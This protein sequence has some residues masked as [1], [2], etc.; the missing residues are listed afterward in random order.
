[1]TSDKL[2]Y[3]ASRRRF[4]RDSTLASIGL[5]AA[6]CA[7]GSTGTTTGG[8]TG[9]AAVGKGGEFHGAW[10]YVLPPAGHWN[11]YAPNGILTTGIYRHL[12]L[13]TLGMY[14][15]NDKKF[16]Y[17][18]AESS[19]PKAGDN[20]ELKLRSGIKWSDGAAFT[21]K[22]VYTTFN[23]GRLENFTLWQYV[24]K[25][26][27]V[28]DQTI[29]FHFSRPSGLAER[30]LL[31]EPIRPDSLFGTYSKET[32]AL[33]AAGK[34]AADQEWRDLRTKMNAFRPTAAVSVGPYKID[35]A[36]VT[37]SQ[38]TFVRNPGGYAADRVNFDKVV[39][40]QGETNQVSPLVLSQDVDYATHGF[41]LAVDKA[42]KDAGIRVAR[43]PLYTGPALYF[44]WEKAPE[45]Q[46]VRLRYAVAHAINKEESAAITYGDSGKAQKY[47][48]GFSDDH[49]PGWLSSADL[50]KLKPYEFSLAK[51]DQFMKDAGYA[52]G[53]DGI[54]AKGGKKLE[55]EL[56]FPSDFA[57]WSSAATHAAES[58][59]KFGIKVTPRGL[60]NSTQQPEVND[61]KHAFFVRAWGIGSAPHPQY[62]FIQDLRTHNTTPPGGGMKYPLKQTLPSTGRQI[63]FDELINRTGDGTDEAK[64]KTAVT[65]LALA[66]N[67]LLPI[68]PLWQRF[69]NNPINDKKRVAGWPA[70]SDGIYKNPDADS[71]AM[72]LLIRGTLGS[73]K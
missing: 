44:H 45:F 22:D 38:L 54:Y 32:D 50:A 17:W 48:A 1:M 64:Q 37:E 11:G 24:D 7:P 58:L 68:I 66:F 62:S 60:V 57:D 28:N 46:D 67:E 20:Y 10:P 56:V 13:T 23:V 14:L 59:T 26:E 47:M 53:S 25:M 5:I 65:E 34:K 15:W 3:T 73:I 2:R 18:L 63:D 33:V 4:L 72:T 49:A 39:V 16:D 69:G 12:W 9:T 21:A 30:L 35:T 55:L 51:A 40:Y 19:G 70:E 31:R 36:T 61:G 6:A 8:T 41:T 71:F 42:M 27:I 29:N 43:P 52:K